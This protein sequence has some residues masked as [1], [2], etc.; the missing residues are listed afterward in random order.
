M[1]WTLETISA[2]LQILLRYI[3]TLFGADIRMCPFVLRGE[4]ENRGI[5]KKLMRVKKVSN[6]ANLFCIDF[7]IAFRTLLYSKAIIHLSVFVNLQTDFNVPTSI[8]WLLITLIFG[9]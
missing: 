6:S 3:L 4:K 2:S 9:T 7:G 8:F 1:F 5:K